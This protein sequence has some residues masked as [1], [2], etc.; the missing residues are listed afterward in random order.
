[1]DEIGT[2]NYSDGG[3]VPDMDLLMLSAFEGLDSFTELVAGPTFRD[4]ILSSSSISPVQQLLHISASSSTVNPEEQGD[5]SIADGSDCTASLASGEFMRMSTATVPRTVHG[6]V[7]LAER[8]LRA[9]AMLR[10][11]SN[12][13]PLLAQVWIPVRNGEHQVLSTSNQPFLLDERLTGYRE[14]SKQFTFSATEGSGLFPGLPGRVFISGM[15]EWTSNVM[16]YNTSEYLRVDYAIRNEVRGSLAMPVFKSSGGTCCAVLEVVMTQEKDNFCAEMDNLSNALQSVHLSTVKA[17]AHPQS[18][19]RSQESAFMEILDVLRAVCHEHTLPLALAWVPV[20]PNSNL[21]VSA[22][23]GDQAIKFGLRNTDVLCVQESA[24]Y[25]SDTR[26]YDFVCACAEHPLEKGQGVAGNAILSN[27]PFFSSDVREYNTH[28]YP[29]AHHARKFGLHA[30]VAIRLRSTYTGND[31]YVLEFFLPLMCRVKEE[32]Q[33]LLDNLSVT[34]QRVCSSLRTVSD[35]E[36]EE[37]G[38][39]KSSGIQCLPSDISIN[40]CIQIDASSAIKT[41][42]PLENQIQSTVEQLVDQEHA[43][44]F[45]Q[46]TTSHGQKIR[47]STEKNVSLSVLQQY[48]AGSLKDAAKSIGVCPTTLKRIC[49]QHGISRWPSRKI[50][51]VNRSLKK[52]H[53]VISSVHGVEA[54]I[55]YDPATGCLVSSVPPLEE[56]SMMNVEHRS[57]DPLSIEFDLSNRKFGH[58]YDAYRREHV[59]KVV[60]TTAEYEKMSEIHITT[61][62]GTLKGPL[63]QDASNDSYITNQMTHVRT[64]MWVEGAERKNIVCN[65]VSM[66]QQFK[67]KKET[68]KDNTNVDHSLPSTSSMTDYSSGVTSSDCPKSQPVNENSMSITVKA[69]YKEH[70]IRLKLLRSMKYQNLVEEIAK[71]L[72]LSASTFQLKYKDDEDEW[73]ILASDADLQECFEV[74]DNTDSHIVKVQVRDVLFATGSSSGSSSTWCR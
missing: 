46:G 32:Q 25:I 23:Y 39:T 40:S 45:K 11:T 68:D 28:D 31:D 42:M 62:H 71:R 29:L 73:V 50:K 54:V 38:I 35:A 17:R 7:N 60:L 30:A 1:M 41:N 12:G 53:N 74:L 67:M 55:K 36:L 27:N 22:E 14:V 16:Y 72:K 33:L 2:P 56:P 65:S 10:K 6:G 49:R 52:I 3:S 58:D 21:N 48:F 47:S 19:T 51:K 57:S 20:C 44:E 59:G 34:M 13:G 43:N 37:D 15:P 18:L 4:S 9:L 64:D 66:P 5:V 24:C 63:C 69:T 61:N 70:N 8:M 26:M